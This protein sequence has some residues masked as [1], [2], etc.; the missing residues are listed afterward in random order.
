M[1]STLKSPPTSR[2]HIIGHLDAPIIMVEYGDYESEHSAHAAGL[3]QKLLKEY[4]HSLCYVYRHLPLIDIH[5]HSALAA[6]AAEAADQQAM[7]WEMHYLLFENYNALSAEN[8]RLMSMNLDLDTDQ[9]L[10]DLAREDLLEHINEDIDSAQRSGVI[11][12]SAIFINGIS[13]D[14]E[15]NLRN[16]KNEIHDLLRENQVSP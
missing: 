12:S 7:F 1:T 2:D 9:F 14:Q 4:K 16:F 10:V 8:I 5:P 11:H 3:V 13:F 15:Y 6:L